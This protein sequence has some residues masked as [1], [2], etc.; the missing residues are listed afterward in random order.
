MGKYDNDTKY[1]D[2]KKIIAESDSPFLKKLPGFVVCLLIKIV[3][4]NEMNHIMT[5]HA[6]YSGVDFLPRLKEELNLKLEIE[7]IENLPENGRCFFAA[8]HPFGLVDGLTL[9]YIVS[10]KYGSLKAIGNE[11]F[12]FI[13]H[14]RPLLAAVNVFGRSPKEYLQALDDTFNSDTPIT[15]FPAGLISRRIDG[16]VQDGEWQKSF[17]TKAIS[18]KRDIVPF[19]FYGKNSGLFY[20][21][22]VVRQ[23]FGIKIRIELIL[24]SREMF[25]KRNKTIRVR[26]GR[27]IPYS[28]FDKSKSHV[29]W[30]ARVRE[31]TY[32]LATGE[33][34]TFVA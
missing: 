16:K 14:L 33:N 6:E 2:L 4:Q 23:W 20:A 27:P 19:Y 21:I 22:D 24:L 13:P 28:V 1:I 7:G 9:T 11:A 17:I 10:Q 15:H 29:E 12:M 26:I 25:R 8:N 5:R 3:R 34:D 30:A 32:G 18:C 31:H